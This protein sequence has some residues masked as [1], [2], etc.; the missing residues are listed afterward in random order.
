MGF[1]QNYIQSNDFKNT[2]RKTTDS[3]VKLIFRWGAWAVMGFFNFI[4]DMFKMGIGK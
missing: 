3:A 4:R 1:L 2:S